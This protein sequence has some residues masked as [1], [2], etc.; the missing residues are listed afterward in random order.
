MNTLSK[1]LWTSEYLRA[2]WN[3]IE[4]RKKN[5]YPWW[6]QTEERTAK[7]VQGKNPTPLSL[8]CYATNEKNALLT[9]PLNKSLSQKISWS[10]AIPKMFQVLN[11]KAL[12]RDK[13]LF[14]S[15]E[16]GES[17]RLREGGEGWISRVRSNWRTDRRGK[18]IYSLTQPLGL[19][20]EGWPCRLV[21]LSHFFPLAVS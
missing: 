18:R 13:L 1:T 2:S 17:L 15:G 14:S 3:K 8:K 10:L 5:I 16:K 11:R 20:G 9:L 19:L 7:K 4:N 6:Y 12:R 21:M